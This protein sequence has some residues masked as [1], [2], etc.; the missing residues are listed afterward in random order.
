MLYI[1]YIEYIFG[2]IKDNIRPAT[3]LQMFSQIGTDGRRILHLIGRILNM[4]QIFDT[5]EISGNVR[6][7]YSL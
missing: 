5:F 4:Y 7:Q 2:K 6:Q 3:M 1:R